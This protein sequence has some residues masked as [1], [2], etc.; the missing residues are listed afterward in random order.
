MRPPIAASRQGCVISS[1]AAGAPLPGLSSKLSYG[2]LPP[3]RRRYCPLRAGGLGDTLAR[4]QTLVSVMRRLEGARIRKN[5]EPV[6]D[7]THETS[8][9]PQGD[10]HRHRRIGHRRA[11]RCAVESRNPL[12]PHRELAEVARYALR[13]VRDLLQVHW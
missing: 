7:L 2:R 13:V 4:K 6:E 5:Q 3:F 8:R 10:R 11:C 9:L 12:A 1:E